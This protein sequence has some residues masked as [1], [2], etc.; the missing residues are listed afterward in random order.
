MITVV[1]LLACI[2]IWL[3]SENKA[4]AKNIII[5]V[6]IIDVIFEGLLAVAMLSG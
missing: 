1:A 5:A 3:V 2:V 6:I 4:R